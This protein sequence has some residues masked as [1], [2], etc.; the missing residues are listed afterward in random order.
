MSIIITKYILFFL[1]FLRP[2]LMSPAFE[3][4]EADLIFSIAFIAFS[5]LYILFLK[6][7][8]SKNFAPTVLIFFLTV[9][10][11]SLLRHPVS[12]KHLYVYIF[13]LS[14]F[15]FA[16][17]EEKKRPLLVLIVVTSMAVALY[18]LRSYFIISRYLLE[19]LE[20]KEINYGFGRE[21][22]QRGRAFAPFFLPSLLGGYLAMAIPICLGFITEEVKLKKRRLFLFFWIICFVCFSLVL[23]LT[24]SIGALVALFCAIAFYLILRRKLNLKILILIFILLTVIASVLY[25]RQS[26][27]DFTKPF[28]SLEKRLSYWRNTWQ[29]IK[30]NPFT[31]KGLGNLSLA[32]SR[33]VHNSYLQLWGESG[34][35]SLLAFLAVIFLFIKKGT[36][37]IKAEGRFCEK[38]VVVAGIVFLI[39]NLIDFTF[40]VSQVSFL[41]WIILAIVLS[42]D[43]F[44][45]P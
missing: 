27:E 34:L 26:G 35:F 15:Y 5:F 14:V 6:K 2:F 16:F 42:R 41:W 11:F 23:Y 33:F 45:R 9:F 20:L 19:Y 32:Q 29:I 39:H 21:F 25:I 13:Y 8:D 18:S 12:L 24:Q 44:G 4:N 17:Y 31:G 22:V 38:G 1:T 28:F 37:K 36:E 10:T 43:S 40:F 30:D 7:F 3:L